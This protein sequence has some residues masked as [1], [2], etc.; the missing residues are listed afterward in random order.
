MRYHSDWIAAYLDYTRHS[1]APT[2]FHYWTAIA[3]IAGAI[4][5]KAYIDMAYFRWFP[6]FYVLFVAPP[7]IVSKSTTADIGMS[8]LRRVPGIHFG[9]SA[10]TWQSFVT[11]LSHSREDFP[12]PDGS[13]TPM[14]AVT[15][16]ASEL[17]TLFQ[18]G[19]TAIVN[20]LT[21]LWDCRDDPFKK[22][23]KKDG[24][25]I[26]E[27]PWINLVGCTTPSW[28]A[29]NFGSYFVEGGFASRV[30]FVY[31]EHKRQL[32]A[33][34]GQRLDGFK[35]LGSDRLTHDLEQI[36]ALSGAF[37]LTPDAFEWGEEWYARHHASDNPL[38]LDPRFGGYFARKQAHL[39]KTAM[40]LS[41]ARGDSL[42]ISK[43]DLQAANTALT[44][45]EPNMMAVFG[46]MNNDKAAEQMALVLTEVRRAGTVSRQDL[47][48]DLMCSMGYGAFQ[49]CIN[50]LQATG[51]VELE[52]RGSLIHL[53]YVDRVERKLTS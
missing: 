17:G 23:T 42:I 38:R 32:V 2:D 41:L 33:Y 24:D 26:V 50:G 10:V 27:N 45:L 12:G 35:A 52:Q 40:V 28:I 21:E 44:A 4:R 34:P 7:G 43:E 36:S 11:S 5:R 19:D 30:L 8:L 13:F 48:R 1:E 49:E 29:E 9:P 51:L 15:M 18:P 37:V 47:Y 31:A 22:Q 6:N 14:C 25:E 53:R 3:C 16:V 39:H 20:L 46:K